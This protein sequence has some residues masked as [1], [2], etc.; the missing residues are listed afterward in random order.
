MT[1]VQA[2]LPILPLYL[3][4]L[5]IDELAMVGQKENFDTIL[6]ILGAVG[7][8]MIARIMIGIVSAY[9]NFLHSDI[10]VDH[11][12]KVVADKSS[13]IDFSYYDSSKFF[14]TFQRAQAQ[15]MGRPLA[16]LGT[17]IGFGKTVLSLIAV[18][19]LL[20]TLHWAIV[21]GIILIAIPAT[22]IRF[23]F[24][25]ELITLQE[26]QTEPQ[27]KAGLFQGML[28]GV[29]FAKDLRIYGYADAIK[30]QYLQLLKSLR[31]ERRALQLKQMLQMS[32]IQSIEII[33]VIAGIAYVT[34]R[35][36]EASISLGD[37][38]LYF[39]LF[40][41]GQ[42][43]VKTFLQSGVAINEH[44][45]F[46]R[47]LFEYLELAPKVVAPPHPTPIPNQVE[48]LTLENVS[49]QYPDTRHPV[50]K[51][52]NVQFKKGQIIAIV[53]ENGSGKTTL[54][55][56]LNRLYDPKSGHI[57]LN[58]NDIKDYDPL[59]YRH[60]ISTLFQQFAKY[61][62]PVNQNIFL[63]D[64]REAPNTER[65]QAVCQ[66]AQ[67]DEFIQAL[68]NGY[69]TQLGRSFWLGEELSGGQWQK[70]A[71][72]R[73][74]YK[75]AQLLILDEPTSQI[76]PIAEDAIFKKLVTL[77]KDK[78]LI[79]ITHRIYNLQIADQILVMDQ[80]QIIERGTHAELMT[81]EGQYFQ[82][83]SSQEVEG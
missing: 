52:I 23:K 10:V 60:H 34:Y 46:A 59:A 15:A 63:A 5:L 1:L 79:L 22:L 78:I 25:K 74:L 14:D 42:S 27:R 38:A 61:D 29:L 37:V 64:M 71:L 36:F 12:A 62:L 11:M 16:V 67:A 18:G 57:R 31:D 24:S 44:K 26:A 40:Q 13:T 65:I 73:S 76:D 48:S 21:F 77:A 9:I 58:G 82:M 49:F 7:L 6:W 50:L 2:I 39:A 66:L 68:P 17:V 56:L 70:I 54:V 33:A 69:Q 43:D 75:D 55:K 32:A 83:F 53:G 72:A 8:V 47:H 41:K 20:M 35:A 81:L 80:G 19:G 4:K 45:L 3:M 30:K 51:N 28:S